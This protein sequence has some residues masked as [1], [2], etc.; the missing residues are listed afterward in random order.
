MWREVGIIIRQAESGEA[1]VEV[2]LPP[3]AERPAGSPNPAA[4]EF[5]PLTLRFLR[6]LCRET[7][8]IS[9]DRIAQEVDLPLDRKVGPL[10]AELAERGWVESLT[11]KGYLLAIPSDREPDAYR[12]AVIA[13]LDRLEAATPAVSPGR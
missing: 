6:I 2:R 10:L 12:R 1:T 5:S 3:E 9:G 7:H 4:K 8:W 13:W 11:G